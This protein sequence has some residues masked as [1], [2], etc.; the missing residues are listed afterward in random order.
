M[1][2]GHDSILTMK[3]TNL[4]PAG[5]TLNVPEAS[6]VLSVHPNTVLKLI[7]GGD[8]PAAKIGR[9]YV[10]LYADVMAYIENLVIHQTAQRQTG[11]AVQK[12]GRR[13]ALLNKPI[14]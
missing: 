4:K 12:R 14:F 8:L 5:S 10:M 11:G 3:F 2:V 9:S 7:L 13:T 1:G 6:D